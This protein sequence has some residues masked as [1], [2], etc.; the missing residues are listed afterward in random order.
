M[1]DNYSLEFY[2]LT[3]SDIDDHADY[4]DCKEPECLLCGLRDCPH[5]EPLHYHHDGCPAGCQ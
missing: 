1:K 4:N 5:G 3:Q 2:G